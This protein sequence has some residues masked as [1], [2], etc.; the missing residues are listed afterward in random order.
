MAFDAFL[1][2]E[3][4]PG[5]S[6]DEKHKNEI[7]VLSFSWGIDRH[8]AAER[9]QGGAGQVKIMD[10]SVTKFTDKASPILF[11]AACEGRQISDATFTARKAGGTQQT[12]LKYVFRDVLISSVQ[13]SGASGSES[14][15]PTE[16]VSLKFGAVEI[17]Y[18]PQGPDGQPLPPVT[19]SCNPGS[20][21]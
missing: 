8:R 12:F 21:E 6:T 18:T 2:I 17:T 5:E 15:V 1:K 19:S 10:F 9:G 20:N 14:S 7:D 16:S 11:D 3:G 13:P 4:I